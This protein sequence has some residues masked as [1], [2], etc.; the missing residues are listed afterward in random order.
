MIVLTGG[1]GF[2]GSN[3][4]RA[5]NANGED[6]L[7]IVDDLSD[8]SKH[9]N[10]ENVRFSDFADKDD[11]LHQLESLNT[12][13]AVIHQGA[14]TVTTETDGRAMMRLNFDYSKRLLHRCARDELPFL[15]ASSA[16]VY[17]YGRS[18]F[19]ESPANE[20]ALNVYAFS[21]LAF[22]NYVRARWQEFRSQVIGLRYFNV[23]GPNERH[24]REMAS[25]PMKL[26]EQHESGQPLTLFAGSAEFYRDFI[27]VDDVVSVNLHFLASGESGIFNC[28]T[29]QARSFQELGEL[30]AAH[31]PGAEIETVPMPDALRGQYQAYTCSDNTALRAAGYQ[32]PFIPLDIGIAKYMRW[33]LEAVAAR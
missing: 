32:R 1:A 5:L 17:G 29:G 31:L 4:A 20:Q 19:A 16:A 15:Y 12:I 13:R 22:D 2:I 27:H 26:F 6:R 3:I 11:F 24:K 9:A 7:L 23:Y 18:G 10:L 14:C 30:V 21:K 25:V 8:G 33:L 28:G